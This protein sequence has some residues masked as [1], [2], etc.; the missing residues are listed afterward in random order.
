MQAAGSPNSQKRKE[1]GD[2]LSDKLIK[3]AIT[4]VLSENS[5]NTPSPAEISRIFATMEASGLAEELKSILQEISRLKEERSEDNEEKVN[6]EIKKLWKKFVILLVSGVCSIIGVVLCSI[7]FPVLG[8]YVW[9]TV[10]PSMCY[11]IGNILG[12]YI[13]DDIIVN[14]F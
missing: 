1:E 6:E 9:G 3:E 12:E 14:M 5:A 8:S 2:S 13:Y 4:K 10:G 11:M 7:Y